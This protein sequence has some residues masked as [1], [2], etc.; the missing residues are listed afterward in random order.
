MIQNFTEL[1]EEWKE[2][3]S[4]AWDKRQGSYYSKFLETLPPRVQHTLNHNKMEDKLSD[5]TCRYPLPSCYISGISH[6]GKTTSIFYGIWQQI[7]FMAKNYVDGLRYTVKVVKIATLMEEIR[8]EF[9]N[10]KEVPYL[11]TLQEVD[12]LVIDDI[13]VEKYTEWSFTQLYLLLDYRYMQMLP[14]WYTSNFSLEELATR[15]P[16][17]R[18]MSRLLAD[19]K[20]HFIEFT[21]K[22]YL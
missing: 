19:C 21:N 6:T 12:L 9:N 5:I 15:L 3:Q 14:T 16:D 18:I 11:Q 7:Q 8:K 13:G 4:S 1:N 22:P 17:E 10:P 20:G 2:H